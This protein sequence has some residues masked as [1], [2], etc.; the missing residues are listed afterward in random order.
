[1]QVHRQC[2]SAF[3]F[4]ADAL[5]FLASHLYAGATGNL[6]HN[7][8]AERDASGVRRSRASLWAM[9]TARRAEFIQRGYQP[10]EAG[11]GGVSLSI[12]SCV[13]RLTLWDT[14][15]PPP[16]ECMPLELVALGWAPAEEGREEPWALANGSP[17][18]REE[19]E[20]ENWCRLRLS[21]TTLCADARGAEFT[22]YHI[23]IE[24]P[25]PDE[26][27]E[28]AREDASDGAAGTQSGTGGVSGRSGDARHPDVQNEVAHR[29]SDFAALDA[30][31]REYR[32]EVMGRLPPLP[33]SMTIN[34]LSSNV[35]HQR[36]GALQ[37]YLDFVA[38][39]HSLAQ[40]EHVRKFLAS[41]PPHC[42]GTTSR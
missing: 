29:Y 39:T 28:E 24:W 14:F 30:A 22:L 3:E 21:H 9:L 18:S 16:A 32:P 7:T 35:I 5:D 33:T 36:V 10:C 1:L 13:S 19:R 37:A 11:G 6:I 25:E 40:L 26:E 17:G 41:P 31:I 4:S 8:D 2:P 27:G 34:K 20:R 42:H 12:S 38:A 23:V 15:L